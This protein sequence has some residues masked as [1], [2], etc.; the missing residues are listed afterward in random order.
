M[1]RPHFFKR[2]PHTIL[3][4]YE[5]ATMNQM[6]P[7][8]RGV[9]LMLRFQSGDTAAFDEVVREYKDTVYAFIYRF[10]GGSQGAEDLAQEVFLR[11]FRSRESYQPDAKFSTWIYR[12]VCNLCI[13]R[14]RDSGRQVVLQSI[15][16]ND[17][18]SRHLSEREDAKSP[19]P[20]KE[21][22]SRELQ[23]QVRLA[24]QELSEKHRAAILLHRFEG[25]SYQ[26]IGDS[27]G[28]S[29]KAVKSMMSRAKEHLR[30]KLKN[31]LQE[32]VA[33]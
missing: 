22:E 32:E 16:E 11:V 33:E 7:R 4:F 10:R 13:N 26:E 25:L 14:V 2:N 6:L 21:M 28:V 20:F 5:G 1:L 12:I 8:D 19:E 15:D 30:T 23:E 18:K 17:E 24:I 31:F 3:G 9:E 29:E 27:M